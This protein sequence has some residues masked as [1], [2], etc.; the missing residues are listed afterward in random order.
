MKL[1]THP[2]NRKEMVRAISELTGLEATYMFTPTYSFQI[3]P[4]TVN[5]D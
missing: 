5:R 1:N 4:I 2:E 3:G